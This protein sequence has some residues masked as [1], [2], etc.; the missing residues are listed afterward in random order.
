MRL[1]AV[2]WVELAWQP[3]TQGSGTG[4]LRLRQPPRWALVSF[5]VASIVGVL[6]SC[7]KSTD[8]GAVNKCAAAVEV[9]AETT[10]EIS[11]AE[12][13][14]TPIEAGERRSVRSVSVGGDVYVW[15]R[16]P[17]DGDRPVP[18]KVPFDAM[19]EAPAGSDYELE[20]L[21][22]GDRCPG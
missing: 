12:I 21:L 19:S 5:G 10:H 4:W 16:S 3:R 8:I 15:V 18:F 9:G 14:F 13:E 22:E 11:D 6:T 1:N 17:G 7:Q 2:A 20:V